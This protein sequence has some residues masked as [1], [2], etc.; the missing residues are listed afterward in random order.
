M[1]ES[2]SPSPVSSRPTSLDNFDL[3]E[4]LF[5]LSGQA[6]TGVLRVRR[7]GDTLEVWLER[8]RLRHVVLGGWSGLKAQGAAAL[9]AFLREPR[10]HF[11]FDEGVHCL[12]PTLD[13]TLDELAL[14]ALDELPLPDLRFDGAA[15]VVSPERLAALPLTPEQREVVA[16]VEAQHPVAAFML[17]PAAR[18]LLN[19][20]GRMGLIT[21]RR[22]RVARL[23]V[24]VSREATGA[25]LLDS[26]IVTRW[27]N[28]L[29]RLPWKV[30]IRAADSATHTLPVRGGAGLGKQLL[31]PPELM[32]RTGL[33]AGTSV[34]V[35]PA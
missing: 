4:L 27:E 13:V 26:L 6:R 28:A 23:T 14:T 35:K 24:G 32:V 29:A 9:A 10:G 25:V 21:A 33:H 12:A 1:P 18:R 5:L 31:V 17:D 19:K 20:L 2:T 3:L 7:P 8:G 11:Q 15:R 30:E 16:R 34:L 22:P